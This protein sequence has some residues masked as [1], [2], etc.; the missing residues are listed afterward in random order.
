M[1]RTDNGTDTEWHRVSAT[2]RGVSSEKVVAGTQ[3]IMRTPATA[4]AIM[5]TRCNLPELLVQ[6]DLAPG[7]DF[8]SPVK[9]RRLDHIAGSF[10]REK[11]ERSLTEAACT[12]V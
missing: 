12:Q 8:A 10:A 1:G 7:L 2:L 11:S 3:V 6:G 9:H 4:A 5:K